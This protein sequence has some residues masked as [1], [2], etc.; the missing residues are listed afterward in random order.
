MYS[1]QTGVAKPPSP[2][3]AAASQQDAF[4]I[5]RTDSGKGYQTLKD[6]FRADDQ[7]RFRAGIISPPTRLATIPRS[8]TSKR[9]RWGFSP[10]TRKLKRRSNWPR[11]T[12][13]VKRCV[14]VLVNRIWTLKPRPR[15]G[16]TAADY[17]KQLDLYKQVDP[18]GYAQRIAQGQGVAQ[19]VSQAGQSGPTGAR[20]CHQGHGTSTNQPSGR[21][22]PVSEAGPARVRL[23]AGAQHLAGSSPSSRPPISWRLGVSWTRSRQMQVEQQARKASG[24]LAVTSTVPV[25]RPWKR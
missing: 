8:L 16:P 3:A 20:L 17:Q 22:N 15:A 14:K 6:E 19:G 24:R 23:D 10:L 5:T 1:I 9:R 13:P 7:R 18:T 21:A 4:G 25:K 11:L 12:R 2:A